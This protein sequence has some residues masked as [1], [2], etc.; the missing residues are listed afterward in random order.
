M[1]FRYDEKGRVEDCKYVDYQLCVYTSPAIDLHYFISTSLAYDALQNIDYLLDFYYIRLLATL[2][3]LKCNLKEIPSLKE[4]KD[5][6][7]RR[8]FYGLTAIAT[9]LPLVRADGRND[10]TFEELLSPD[11]SE[12]GF[13]YHCYNNNSYKK[14]TIRLLSI[15]DKLGAFC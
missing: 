11:A 12:N 9:V 6:F 14:A 5:D 15:Y 10:A 8:S 3:K 7:R 13:R 4:F 2:N 1:M